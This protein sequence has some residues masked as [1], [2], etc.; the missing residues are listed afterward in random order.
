MTAAFASTD[1]AYPLIWGSV[2]DKVHEDIA[3]LAI[4]TPVQKPGRVTY[5][6]V[7][8]ATNRIVGF[9]IWTLLA[10]KKE[11]A[12]DTSGGV[13]DIPGV[14]MDLWRWK[15]A[16]GRTAWGSKMDRSKDMY[17]N[18]QVT[19][20][21][22]FVALHEH[23]IRLLDLQPGNFD[24]GI[25]CTLRIVSLDDLP[26]YEA[27][28][29]VWGDPAATQTIS[30][31]GN[32]FL[33]SSNLILALKQIRRPKD[34]RSLW[35][36]S[37]C[38]NQKNGMEKINQIKI[39]RDIY[40][41]CNRGLLWF[42]EPDTFEY[43]EIQDVFDFLQRVAYHEA[44]ASRDISKRTCEAIVGMIRTPWWT[45]MWT[46]QEALLPKSATVLWGNK[47]CQWKT[48]ED[49]ADVMCTTNEVEMTFWQGQMIDHFLSRVRALS[50][51]RQIK[52]ADLLP[53]LVRFFPRVATDPRDKIFG[54]LG[55]VPE[56]DRHFINVYNFDYNTDMVHLCYQMALDMIHAI[57]GLEPLLS[58]TG[59]P[60]PNPKMPSWVF[61]WSSNDSEE[62]GLLPNT[63]CHFWNHYWRDRFYDASLNQGCPM[64]TDRETLTLTLQGLQIDTIVA[65]FPMQD[66]L[67][68]SNGHADMAVLNTFMSTIS[69]HLSFESPYP[70]PY[71]SSNP[72]P[73][74]NLTNL[75]ALWRTLL[76]DLIT[77]VNGSYPR[78]WAGQ[79]DGTQLLDS[80][81]HKS[82]IGQCLCHS[83]MGSQNHVCFVTAAGYIGQGPKYTR[84]QDRVYV[85]LGA[86]TPYVLR[87]VEGGGD[88][89][90][91]LVGDCYIHGF[92]RGEAVDREGGKKQESVVLH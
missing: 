83:V 69:T 22:P 75:E 59:G 61:D 16:S 70:Y 2:G 46:V 32:P 85:L 25:Q 5:T 15:L 81:N 41:K 9:T 84:C 47:A 67:E 14:N 30:L 27:L 66:S 68:L 31:D 73:D 57:G 39:M 33:V 49:A 38:I 26:S 72:N 10:E 71:S 88:G 21:I 78:R 92:M 43:S 3:K 1:Q 77:D 91:T 12:V 6:A 76:G 42:G 4:F 89:H 82:C 18:Q 65:I 51:T 34:I 60:Q 28:S 56:E 50:F 37:V 74:P 40:G 55:L 64:S 19:G 45:R 86:R 63:Q 79:S 8:S 62:R 35:V 54:L 52:A 13:P 90:F 48:I 11:E 44:I 7:E 36:D 87:P 58:F 23:Q 53:T 24:D 20:P 29:Y 17:S 80:I